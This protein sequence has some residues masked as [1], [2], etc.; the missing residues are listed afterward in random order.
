MTAKL[1]FSHYAIIG[2]M[3]FGLFF[4][5]GNLIFPL[6]LGQLSGD[7]VWL[8]IAGFLISGI[9]LPFLG[10]LSIGYANGQTVQQLAARVHPWYGVIFTLALYLTIGPLF[11]LPRTGTVSYEIGISSFI[12]KDQ[13]WL[14]LAVYTLIYFA[15]T[16][17][18]SLNPARIVLWVGKI[19]TPIFLLFI[20]IIV[21]LS[22]VSPMGGL[23][24]PQPPYVDNAFAQG[25]LEGYNT[26]D[27]LASLAFGIIVVNAI[28][29]YGITNSKQI[30]YVTTKAGV[31]GMVLMAIIY[32]A[33][34]YVGASSVQTIGRFENGGLILANV[35][36]HYVGSYVGPFLAI[37]I[38]LTCI[39][40]AIGLVS[41][42]A[43]CFHDYFPSISY[44]KFAI[45]VSIAA[46]L[47]ANVGLTNIINFAIPI[48]MLI[49]PLTLALILLVFFAKSRITY[50]LTIILTLLSSSFDAI[51]SAMTV[52]HLNSQSP[53]GET[54]FELHHYLPLYA[55]GLGWILPMVIG[56]VLGNVMTLFMAKQSKQDK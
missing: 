45:L 53:F 39:T 9:G 10:V 35:V 13:Q 8:A 54:I 28:K 16:L 30:V 42:C 41:A 55:M 40:T 19:L 6:F 17:Y 24:S 37:L 1:S 5:A 12:A 52:F 56:L 18:F 3:L 26:M 38:F 11:A 47:I 20:L 33:I 43:S 31:I 50:L 46:G 14:G 27:A 21:V 2:T 44:K 51:K 34:A 49:C 32:V 22:I 15:C 7:H 36:Y 25:I 48:L 29:Q 4:G 23:M